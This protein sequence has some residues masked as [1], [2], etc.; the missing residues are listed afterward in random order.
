M[1][2]HCYEGKLQLIQIHSLSWE[3]VSS[4]VLPAGDLILLQVPYCPGREHEH[5]NKASPNQCFQLAQ[6]DP[7]VRLLSKSSRTYKLLLAQYGPYTVALTAGLLPQHSVRPP[8]HLDYRRCKSPSLT[9]GLNGVRTL[10]PRMGSQR[11]IHYANPLL[12]ETGLNYHSVTHYHHFHYSM[13]FCDVQTAR[14]EK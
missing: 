12:V 8:I 11:L 13:L 9:T 1:T 6:R 4:K 3:S 10:A 5:V 14:Q 2:V 7:V